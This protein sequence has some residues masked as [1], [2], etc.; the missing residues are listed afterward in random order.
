MNISF[1]IPS[2]NNL[3]YLKW[4]YAALRSN[5]SHTNHEICVADDASSDGTWE[6][7]EE[8]HKQ[9]PH[10][11]AVRNEG[12]AR[13]GMTE[14][15]NILVEQAAT[16]DVIMIY[17]ADMYISRNAD[18]LIEKYLKPQTVVS[19]TRIEPPLHPGGPE[20]ITQDFGSEPETFKKDEF[21][22][23]LLNTKVNRKD[24]TTEGVFAPW[25]IYK[26]DFLKIGGHDLLFAPTSKE[27]SD[28]F[29]RFLLN[30]YKFIQIWEACVYHLTCRGSRFNPTL[31]AI[32]KDSEEWQQQNV[33]SSRNFIRKWGHFVKHNDFMKPVVPNRYNI[34]FVALNCDEYRVALLEPWCD[35]LYTDVDYTRYIAAEQKNTKF[36]LKK[37]LKQYDEPKLN[38][39]VVT[40]DA[41][42][43]SNQS[44]EFFNMLQLML[45]DS[46]QVGNL[47]Y[48]IFKLQINRLVDCKKNLI[49]VDNAEYK[50]WLL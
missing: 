12:P 13:K 26:E 49:N 48:D 41:N 36:D 40:F 27:D 17:H 45:E 22:K 42:K 29:N 14:L 16:N 35:A 46:G 28:I 33:K 6:W 9:D 3:K 20:K 23:W 50:K 39:V 11:K 24:K 10:F 5:L 1:I 30:D 38:D 18:L 21:E 19:L 4:C 37:K 32:G 31:T 25:A 7:C 34:G 47:E 15:Y 43:I 44:F 8:M 2:R